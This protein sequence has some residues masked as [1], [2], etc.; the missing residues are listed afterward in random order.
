MELRFGKWDVF[1]IKKM[2]INYEI[3]PRLSKMKKRKVYRIVYRWWYEYERLF[4][5]ERTE[6]CQ[7]QVKR[8][9]LDWQHVD[10]LKIVIISL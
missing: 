7:L 1:F 4:G 5:H 3:Q 6:L 9:P 10:I 2:T 8:F